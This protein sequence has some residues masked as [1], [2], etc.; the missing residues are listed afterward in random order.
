MKKH[1]E[2][3][4]QLSFLFWNIYWEWEYQSFK[5]TS[6]FSNYK[7]QYIKL[8]KTIRKSVKDN[9]L[10]SDDYFL[11][12]INNEIEESINDCKKSKDINDL[13]AEIICFFSNFSFLLLW[14]RPDNFWF[15]KIYF[16]KTK[17]INSNWKLNDFRSI[18]Y[19]QT[20]EQKRNLKK[21]Y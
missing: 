5:D 10:I 2:I 13:N 12:E 20:E 11:E 3:P 19:I 17:K 21:V 8:I 4:I 14:N 15:D 7:N 6:S 1:I 9:I 16:S 18:Q